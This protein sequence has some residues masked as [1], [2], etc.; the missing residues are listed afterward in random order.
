[1]GKNQNI[2]QKQY[3]HKFNKTLK[4]VHIKKK[5][6]KKKRKGENPCIF[7]AS[8]STLVLLISSFLDSTFFMF[9]KLKKK[10]IHLFLFIW[11]LQVLVATCML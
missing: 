5:K 4:I 11:L 8:R 2:Q 10:N 3:Y 1:M 9:L 7:M 6:K